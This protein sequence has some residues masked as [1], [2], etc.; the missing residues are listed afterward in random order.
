MHSSHVQYKKYGPNT[1]INV[2]AKNDNKGQLCLTL[3]H[4]VLSLRAQSQHV[5]I[6]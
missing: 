3:L 2:K 1:K 5:V 4:H 6:P